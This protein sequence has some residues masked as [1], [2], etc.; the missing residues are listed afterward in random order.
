[1]VAQ[2]FAFVARL[3]PDVR[4]SGWKLLYQFMAFK[5]RDADWAFMNYGLIDL[6][7]QA[8]PP[9]L[10]PADEK[11]RYCIQLYHHVTSAIDLTG[12]DVLEV[13]CGRGGGCSF[14]AR[15]LQPRSVVGV[16]ISE[17]AIHICNKFHAGPRLTFFRGDAESLPFDDGAVDAVVNV[18]SSHCYGSMPRFLSEV[19][20]VLR[21][22]GYFLFADLRD[23][24]DVGR[25]REQMEASHM[26]I[27]KGQTITDGIL[28]ALDQDSERKKRFVRQKAPRI[29]RGAF[30]EFAGLRGTRLY[31]EFRSGRAQYLSLV[32]RK[33]SP[34]GAS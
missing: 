3:S 32:L 30:Q 15:Y 20:R 17:R 2:A 16:D 18:E 31:E 28:A 5:N 26:Q 10:S 13:G 7:P 33:T 4:R 24:N 19:H 29:L 21:P 6:D 11:D 1:M 14:M 8:K 22:G 12:R 9:H 27:I 34:R 23:R 25:L